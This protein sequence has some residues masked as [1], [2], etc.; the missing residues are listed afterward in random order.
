MSKLY[1][2]EQGDV[3][4]IE[5]F[6]DEARC[7]G[8]GGRGTVDDVRRRKLRTLGG[9]VKLRV[10]VRKCTEPSCPLFGQRL[11]GEVEL[12]FAPPHWTVSWDLFAWMG[13]RRFGRHWS[14]PQIRHELEDRF[15]VAASEDWI[16]DYLA[17]YQAIVAGRESDIELMAKAYAGTDDLILTIDG[18]QPEKGHETLYVVREVRLQRIWFAQPLPCSSHDEVGALI[19]HAKQLADALG[20][21][22]RCWM[23]DKQQVLVTCIAETFPGVPHRYCNNHFLRDLAKPVLDKDSQ[24]KVQMRSHV[25][26]LRRIEKRMLSRTHELEQEKAAQTAASGTGLEPL[27]VAPPIPLETVTDQ[28]EAVL[29]YCA[30]VRG[31]LNDDQGGPLLPAGIR[32]DVALQDVQSSLDRV[33]A[34]RGGR[35]RDPTKS[36]TDGQIDPTCRQELENL[37]SC[38]ERGRSLVADELQVVRMHTQQVTAIWALLS[39]EAGPGSERR[40]R[41]SALATQL[42]GSD[43]PLQQHM[44]RI[45][46]AFVAGLFVGDDEDGQMPVD[47]LELERALRV[48]KAHER[49][50]HG[51][52][53]AGMRIVHQ[54]A[55]LVIVLDAHQRHAAPFHQDELI[56]YLH[57]QPPGT[58]LAA[59]QRQR[60]MRQGRSTKNRA[61]LLSCFEARFRGQKH[62]SPV[63]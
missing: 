51:H 22:V 56:P 39:S 55:T 47:N 61:K 13:H 45:M 12:S 1:W 18:V 9:R 37:R 40:E 32:M 5:A 20:K 52:A 60:V 19:K 48:P 57:A 26:G 63:T 43:D 7:V 54:G 2:P 29:D 33:L 4:V 24:A 42:V 35:R 31:I 41:F 17:R 49:H 50:V 25:R 6:L 44:G 46:F 53:H 3:P 59:L 21:K 38:I 27:L 28:H 11:G 15:G 62:R 34:P 36:R 8:C 23:S 10:P 58:Q 30:C 16:E 14:V